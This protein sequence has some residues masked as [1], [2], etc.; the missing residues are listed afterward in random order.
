[1]S[2][3][4]QA[5]IKSVK[6]NLSQKSSKKRYFDRKVNSN[7]EFTAIKNAPKLSPE[8]LEAFSTQ[9]KEDL[10]KWRTKVW[11]ITLISCSILFTVLYFLFS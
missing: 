6:A 11:G 9:F 2:T 1:M 4:G 8:E 10:R 3:A 7:Q 5:M